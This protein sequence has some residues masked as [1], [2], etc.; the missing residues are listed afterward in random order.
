VSRRAGYDIN[1]VYEI[2]DITRHDVVAF[3]QAMA[4]K[5]KSPASRWIHLGMT[6]SD[7]LDTTFAVQL[8]E[9]ADIIIK[10]IKDFMRVLKRKAR[11]YKNTVMIGRSQA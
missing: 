9:A 4:E 6:S 10:D 8:V 2:E 1:R 3:T 5:I 11:K 7:L